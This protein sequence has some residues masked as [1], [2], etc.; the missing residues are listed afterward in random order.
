MKLRCVLVWQQLASRVQFECWWTLACCVCKLGVRSEFSCSE[1]LQIR[2]SFSVSSS[3]Q[4]YVIPL[5]LPGDPRGRR[6]GG[7]KRVGDVTSR[8]HI[9]IL[10]KYH[11]C[12]YMCIYMFLSP[13]CALSAER[14]RKKYL[15]VVDQKKT[16]NVVENKRLTPFWSS[17]HTCSLALTHTQIIS[18]KIHTRR[19]HTTPNGR[20]LWGY[21]TATHCNALQRTALNR[22]RH[23]IL[24]DCN[25]L[26]HTA[27]H[28]PE[29]NTNMRLLVC[30]TLQYTTIHCDAR[31]STE[32]DTCIYAAIK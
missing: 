27:P 6:R 12:I 9:H 24:L 22:R 25:T 14:D 3:C 23:V 16:R 8:S 19:V 1:F 15:L 20:R 10:M 4:C 32:H 11:T 17:K 28:G 30:N 13:S 31:F 2:F 26:Q 5:S 7:E 21:S 18:A 29:R